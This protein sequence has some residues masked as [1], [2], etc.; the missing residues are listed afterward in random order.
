MRWIYEGKAHQQTHLHFEDEMGCEPANCVLRALH[1]P[2]STFVDYTA[3]AAEGIFDL[4]CP[5]PLP[6]GLENYPP[7]PDNIPSSGL[8]SASLDHSLPDCSPQLPVSA[9]HSTIGGE[10]ESGVLGDFEVAEAQQNAGLKRKNPDGE[11]GGLN[12]QGMRKKT[13]KFFGN[14]LR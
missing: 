1:G 2:L 6:Y 14:S 8:S 7:I 5:S 12:Q 13:S 3:M 10:E 9:D 11:M 4:S